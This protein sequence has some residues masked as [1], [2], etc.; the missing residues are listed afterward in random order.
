[1]T[2]LAERV[3][4]L[5]RRDAETWETIKL[6]KALCDNTNVRL[7]AVSGRLDVLCTLVFE[8][9]VLPPLPPRDAS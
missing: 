7:D 1:V 3:D 4:R 2:E 9:F 5:D 8:R 6:L